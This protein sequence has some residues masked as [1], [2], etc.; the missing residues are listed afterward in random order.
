MQK[1]LSFF[2]TLVSKADNLSFNANLTKIEKQLL[3]LEANTHDLISS[4]QPTKIKKSSLSTCLNTFTL[5]MNRLYDP[6]GKRKRSNSK[7]INE[8]LRGCAR[9]ILLLEKSAS[10]CFDYRILAPTYMCD[11]LKEKLNGFHIEFEQQLKDLK[12]RKDL[13]KVVLDPIRKNYKKKR[14]IRFQRFFYLE[15]YCFWISE[16]LENE[17]HFMGPECGLIRLLITKNLNS[18]S[19][20]SFL[21]KYLD[22]KLNSEYQLEGKIQTLSNLNICLQDLSPVGDL[23]YSHNKASVAKL[24]RSSLSNRISHFKEM[25]KNLPRHFQSETHSE[26]CLKIKTT[27]KIDQLGIL[28]RLLQNEPW[29]KNTSCSEITEAFASIFCF[30]N[31][32]PISKSNLRNQYYNK[33]KKSLI[34]MKKTLLAWLEKIDSDLY[35]TNYKKVSK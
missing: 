21:I 5:L 20:Q 35:E 12:I 19:F 32:A 17:S 25:R 30:E 11:K 18:E 22:E 33:D 31:S 29:I 1:N 7:E 8:T 4:D 26:Q 16:F 15:R 13:I 9:F 28:C 34:E 14:E 2:K 24:L 6:S 23:K 10:Y 27:G 3:L